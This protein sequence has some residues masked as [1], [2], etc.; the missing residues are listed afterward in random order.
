MGHLVWLS[1]TTAAVSLWQRRGPHRGLHSARGGVGLWCEW[2]W[3]GGKASTGRK[4]PPRGSNP[5]RSCH[6][7][8]HL[9]CQQF[10]AFQKPHRRKMETQN[11]LHKPTSH[12]VGARATE[13]RPQARGAERGPVPAGAALAGGRPCGQGIGAQRRLKTGGPSARKGSERARCL[14]AAPP[15]LGWGAGQAK[16]PPRVGPAPGRGKPALL[17]PS[18]ALSSADPAELR[19]RSRLR[20]RSGPR[21]ASPLAAPRPAS[22][23][24]WAAATDARKPA[25]RW[26]TETQAAL[27]GEGPQVA[28]RGQHQGLHKAH[29]AVSRGAPGPLTPR[30]GPPA[31]AHLALHPFIAPARV[32]V[33][34]ELSARTPMPVSG[35]RPKARVPGRLRSAGAPPG[36]GSGRAGLRPSL[37]PTRARRRPRPRPPSRPAPHGAGGAPRRPSPGA[38]CPPSPARPPSAQSAGGAERVALALRR[39]RP[40][41]PSSSAREPSKWPVLFR[42]CFSECL[43]F[44]IFPFKTV[45][46]KHLLKPRGQGKYLQQ[47]FKPSGFRGKMGLRRL[48]DFTL[49]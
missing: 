42:S 23:A 7:K 17:S 28:G 34:V 15:S 10:R 26:G 14:P 38:G 19:A 5:G 24:P 32:V 9:L 33:S 13:R 48:M 16:E 27:S 22:G 46:M 30:R 11:H 39:R 36:A 21:S 44:F 45:T 20:S 18:Q 37:P 40:G 8:W 29:A 43:L 1:V 4:E 3:G 31:P 2:T 47:L 35:P 6:R 25:P 49:E 12:Q 41:R